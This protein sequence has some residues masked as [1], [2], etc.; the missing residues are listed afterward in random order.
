MRLRGSLSNPPT[1]FDDLSRTANL[2]NRTAEGPPVEASNRQGCRQLRKLTPHELESLITEYQDGA[3]AR[4]LAAKY[5]IHRMTVT[6]HIQRSGHQTRPVRSFEGDQLQQL[7]ADYRAGN[8][9]NALG[10]KYGV[11]GSTVSRTLRQHGIGLR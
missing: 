8:S 5:G 9:T 10:R 2:P 7:I 4:D 11:A 1:G 6:R 3:T